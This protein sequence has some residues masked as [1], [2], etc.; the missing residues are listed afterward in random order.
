MDTVLL[1]ARLLLAAVFLTAGVAKLRDR[2]GSVEAMAGFGLPV[3]LARPA[4]TLLPIAELAV[5]AA[6]LPRASVVW[7][8]VSAAAL[9]AVFLVA[10]LVNLGKGR[11]PD[12][13]CF[14]Q[15]H[16]SPAGWSTAVRNALLAGTA[17]FVAWRSGH[18]PGP[19]VTAWTA[20]LGPAGVA[21]LAGASVV[22]A[23]L[24]LQGWLIA[25]LLRQHGRLLLRIDALE[26]GAGSGGAANAGHAAVG[27]PAGLPV[28]SEA[29]EFALP[30]L[31]GET[32]TLTAL[33]A[34]GRPVLLL[35]TSAS[36]GPCEELMPEVGRWQ[37]AHGDTLTIAPISAG[38]PDA[39]RAMA[40]EHGLAN[41]LLQDD[42][43]VA[44]S[45]RYAGTPGAVLV[46]P[47]GRIGS[48][49]VGGAAGVRSLLDRSVPAP[50][51]PPGPR[52]GDPAPSFTLPDLDGDPVDSSVFGVG[53]TLVVFWNPS[54]G[55]CQK[56]L[57]ELHAWDASP[58]RAQGGPRLLLVS[59][60]T[61]EENRA[62]GLRSTVLLDRGS[63]V[64]SAFGAHGSPMGV[65]VDEQGR[66]ASEVA[67][68]A[69]AVL[70]LVGDR[71]PDHQTGIP[72]GAGR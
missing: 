33:R 48:P 42:Y 10:I 26:A 68:G 28:G 40:R 46:T 8:A 4:A 22:L 23:A 37:Q 65:L 1:V 60:G 43:E 47:D 7:G 55:F 19:S 6:L 16:S 9:L 59:T 27:A 53:P 58:A 63:T 21:A 12:C 67:A 71:T 41:V 50:A 45:Y 34:A 20:D 24:A 51:P 25:Q 5:A 3:R 36:C 15:L 32:L 72:A 11:R 39:V 66:L 56:M 30:D 44:E 70:A 17:A 61:V 62:M 13:H 31:H 2:A 54:C 64:A 18:D 29:P 49:V 52:P 38:P 35:F 57:P 69:Q 14:G